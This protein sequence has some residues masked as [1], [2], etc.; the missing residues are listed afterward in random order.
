MCADHAV[1]GK[2]MHVG[3][4]II[5]NVYFL[6]PAARGDKRDLGYRETF[7]ASFCNALVAAPLSFPASSET[8]RVILSPLLTVI[9]GVSS[10]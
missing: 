4:V 1:M 9:V 3:A 10:P 2:L 7:V 8:V 6:F 5:G